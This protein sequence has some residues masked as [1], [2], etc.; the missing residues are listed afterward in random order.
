MEVKIDMCGHISSPS[1]SLLPGT[2][3][4]ALRMPFQRLYSR[5]IPPILYFHICFSAL[6][7]SPFLPSPI[8]SWRTGTIIVTWF[9]FPVDFKFQGTGT[10]AMCSGNF[11]IYLQYCIHSD[12]FSNLKL[13]SAHNLFINEVKRHHC[14]NF[15]LM[16]CFQS[17]H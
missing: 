13:F 3:S 16:Y 10:G 1:S 11:L 14:L 5:S 17:L 15:F 8:S 7:A 2:T 4:Q 12:E 6:A 9:Y